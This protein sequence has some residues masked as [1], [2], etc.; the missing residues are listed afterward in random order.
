[1]TNVDFDK[2][3]EYLEL[4][5]NAAWALKNKGETLSNGYKVKEVIAKSGI[6][7]SNFKA[8]LYERN[9]DYVLAF[10]G[11]DFSSPKDIGANLKMLIGQNPKQFKDAEEFTNKIMKEYK[12][13]I[14]K[15]S[16]T[17]NSEGASEAVHIK[18]VIGAKELYTYNGFIPKLDKYNH[19]NLEN[20]Y[21]FRTPEDIVSKAGQ[22]V[23][24]DFIVPLKDDVNIQKGPN[25][26]ADYHRIINMGD[27][28]KSTEPAVY[29]KNNPEFKNKYREDT[30]KSY[31]IQEI[32]KEMYALFD[33]DIND[34]LKNNAVINKKRKFT[35]D[36]AKCA[37][38]Y[39][40][41]AYTREDG[42]KVADYYRN[43]TASHSN[44]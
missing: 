17:G 38:K 41:K 35:S 7:Q 3:N 15:L 31:E 40:V 32:P 19:E 26:I 11:T 44:G 22:S 10:L 5:N 16:L 9:G 12:F 8:V 1:M 6:R 27:C 4:C 42:T 28:K 25:A 14:D 30:L 33:D 36:S 23:G 2:A 21:N 24:E 29:K 43:C 37:G 18:A 39:H 20:I 34:R 13:S